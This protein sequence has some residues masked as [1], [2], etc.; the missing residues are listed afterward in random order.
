M[1]LHIQFVTLLGVALGLVTAQQLKS[2]KSP[3]GILRVVITSVSK[4]CPEDRLVIRNRHGALFYRK[5]FSSSDCE[6]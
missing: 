5:D 4:S 1:L 2:Y 6:H 3:D